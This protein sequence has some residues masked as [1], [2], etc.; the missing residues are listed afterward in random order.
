M[1]F[2]SPDRSSTTWLPKLSSRCSPGST[3]KQS[4]P[5]K[6]TSST[7]HSLVSFSS[8]LHSITHK[9]HTSPFHH[10]QDPCLPHQ[11]R[12]HVHRR[13]HRLLREP[14]RP[15]RRLPLRRHAPNPVQAPVYSTRLRE[16]DSH[17]PWSGRKSTSTLLQRWA[18]L[19]GPR[20]RHG[21]RR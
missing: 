15:S 19:I 17:R 12:R 8:H 20:T 10:V 21:G 6:L 16:R 9:R 18:L 1:T 3:Y 5:L 4:Y 14:P 13:L 11:T 7:H 2:M